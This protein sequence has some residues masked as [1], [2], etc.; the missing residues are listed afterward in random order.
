MTEASI[1]KIFLLLKFLSEICFKNQ[2]L[3]FVAYFAYYFFPW[4]KI[5]QTLKEL[6]IS[7]SKYNQIYLTSYDLSQIYNNAATI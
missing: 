6:Q 5:K 1:A 3:I 4:R 2:I 7:N